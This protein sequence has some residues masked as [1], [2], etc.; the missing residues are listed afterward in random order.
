MNYLTIFFNS[1]LFR[2]CFKENFPELLGES[3]E[4]RKVFFEN[5]NVKKV[6]DETWYSEMLGK[7]LS[8][9]SSGLSIVDLQN[10]VDEKLFELYE[11]NEQERRL[12][13]SHAS[14]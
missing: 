9:M 8:N 11:L 4:L 2:F 7:I 5:I 6:V 3:R 13:Q 14:I 10:Q 1:R 12:V